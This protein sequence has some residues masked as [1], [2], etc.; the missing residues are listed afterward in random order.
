MNTYFHINYEFDREAVHASIA[1]HV[2]DGEAGY[3][4]VADGVILAH[5]HIDPAY[6]DIINGGMFSVCDSSYVPL[7]L[8]W[9]YGLRYRQYAGSQIFKDIVKS[10]KYRMYFMGA[11]RRTLDGLRQTLSKYN[12]AVGDMT[13]EELP[14]CGVEDFDY[15]AIARRVE[16]DGAQIIWVALG[17][18]KQ[19]IFMH[20]LLPHLGSG[21]MIAVGAA[22]KFYSGV[23]TPRAPKWAVDNHLEWV[24]RI[25]REPGK[26]LGRCMLIIRTLPGILFGEFRRKKIHNAF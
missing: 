9:I 4:C 22:F 21:V 11:N 5:V 14:F 8:R 26:Q 10:K 12:D 17:A 13:F 18:P 2:C 3:I 16:E 19:E 1:E 6:R 24:D 20:R 25:I 23:E 15:S 7:Y